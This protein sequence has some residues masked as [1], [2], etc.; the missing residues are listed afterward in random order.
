MLASTSHYVG[1]PLHVAMGHLLA[2]ILQFLGMAIGSGGDDRTALSSADCPHLQTID[3]HNGGI[4]P[5]VNIFH[6]VRALGRIS[7]VYVVVVPE[8]KRDIPRSLGKYRGSRD[9]CQGSR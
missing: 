6:P 5:D 2:V 1:K 8:A 4:Y 7:G 3:C 9:T